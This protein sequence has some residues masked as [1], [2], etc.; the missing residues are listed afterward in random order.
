MNTAYEEMSQRLIRAVPYPSPEGIQT[1]LDQLGK[2][3]PQ[4]KTF[5][6]ADFI[7]PS[8]LKEIETS[9]FVKNLYSK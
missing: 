5:K 4:I 6:P 7:D 2:A 8:I 1:I 3:R 9:G